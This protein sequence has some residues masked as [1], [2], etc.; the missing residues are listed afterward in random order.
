[1]TLIHA[2]FSSE[3]ALRHGSSI[4]QKP[5]GSMVN[6]T[7]TNDD[8]QAK[9]SRRCDEN[10]VGEVTRAEDGGCVQTNRL[11]PGITP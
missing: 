3:Q 1:M 10:Y 9:P 4:Y 6:V 5:D 7:R 2:W 11:V 8:R